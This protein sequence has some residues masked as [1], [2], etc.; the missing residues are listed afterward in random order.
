MVISLVAV[1]LSAVS[2]AKPAY[3]HF[4]VEDTNTGVK[5]VFHVTPDHSPVAGQESVISFDFAK[6]SFLAKDFTYS[7][8]VKSTKGEPVTV[9]FDVTS[10]VILATY[11]FPSQGFYNVRLAATSLKDGTLS[12]L[13]YGQRV[14]RGV[15]VEQ[16][17]ALSPG[18]IG[19]MVAVGVI[20]VGGIIYALRSDSIARKGKNHEAKNR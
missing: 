14:S 2:I 6:T 7:L 12:T 17:T 4:M 3:A 18:E 10:N 9:P 20:A 16:R 8:T 15:I 13:Q 19:I 11:S 5:A 1:V